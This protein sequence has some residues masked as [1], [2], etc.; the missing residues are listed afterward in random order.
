MG[1]VDVDF[2]KSSLPTLFSS[3][4]AAHA[5]SQTKPAHLTSRASA[6]GPGDRSRLKIRSV[7]TLHSFRGLRRGS[8]LLGCIGNG[9]RGL[10]TR[11][12]QS[13]V[14]SCSQFGFRQCAGD[15]LT[16]NEQ[17]WRTVHPQ[18]LP[19]FIE[20][21]TADSSCLVTHASSLVRS[22][23]ERS[24]SLWVSLSSICHEACGSRVDPLIS[25]PCAWT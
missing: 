6:S 23:E 18:V 4:A 2:S 20:A 25:S 24:P 15:T 9:R 8:R 16:V 13:A 14:D 11:F 19:S 3:G 12:T 22:R 21:R 5:G 17:C 1:Q 7:P 10:Y